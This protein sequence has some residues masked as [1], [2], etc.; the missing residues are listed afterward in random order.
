MKKTCYFVTRYLLLFGLASFIGWLYEI[1]CVW[2]MFHTY[3]DRGVLH[4][5]LCPIYGFGILFLILI[6]RKVKNPFALFLCCVLVTTVI[7]YC[8]ALLIESIL[9]QSLW[10]YKGWP[11]NF[12][13]RISGLSSAIFGLLAVFFIKLIKPPVDKLFESRYRSAAAVVVGVLFVLAVV[14][15]LMAMGGFVSGQLFA[16]MGAP[17]VPVDAFQ[18]GTVAVIRHVVGRF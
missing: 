2:V 14:W 10:T 9:H 4:L 16:Q 12:Q 1:G 15:E 6:F 8:S 13:N 3:Y 11:L 5:P 7:E 18:A 17:F